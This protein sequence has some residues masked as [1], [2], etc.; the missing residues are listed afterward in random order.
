VPLLTDA[1]KGYMTYESTTFEK[2]VEARRRAMAAADTGSPAAQGRD[3]HELAT[4]TRGLVALVED[5]PD[6]KTNERVLELQR[7]LVEIEDKLQYARRDDDAFEG[8]LALGGAQMGWARRTEPESRDVPTDD[9]PPVAHERVGDRLHQA[10]RI[11]RHSLVG[12]KNA[13]SVV[14]SDRRLEPSPCT[15]TLAGAR[16][17]SASV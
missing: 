16:T 15:S 1:V 13:A 4:A 10:K 3:E 14:L 5:Y 11:A 12:K 7:S 6:L 8:K 9:L 2:V 17:R